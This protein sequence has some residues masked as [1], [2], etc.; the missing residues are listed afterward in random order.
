MTPHELLIKLNDYIVSE[1]NSMQFWNIGN[2][3]W[4]S[5]EIYLMIKKFLD[6]WNCVLRHVISTSSV[7]RNLRITA[8]MAHSCPVPTLKSFAD[9]TPFAVLFRDVG[10]L[11]YASDLFPSNHIFAVLNCTF[12]ALCVRN[13]VNQ[14]EE[15]FLY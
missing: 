2:A 7:L 3:I 8:Y 13:P 6:F 12:I 4:K 10:V 1:N 9:A 11:V 5:F 14:S 15:V